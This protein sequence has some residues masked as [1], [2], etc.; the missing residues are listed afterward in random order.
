MGQVKHVD[1]LSVSNIKT[2]AEGEDEETH[3]LVL[4]W[5]VERSEEMKAQV[6]SS[7]AGKRG[8]VDNVKSW[9]RIESGMRAWSPAPSRVVIRTDLPLPRPVPR[10]PYISMLATAVKAYLHP[11]LS[12]EDSQTQDNYQI[13]ARIALNRTS[14][15]L[16]AVAEG[17]ETVLPNIRL[18]S[19][20]KYVLPI[21]RKESTSS[22]VVKMLTKGRLPPRCSIK[23]NRVVIFHKHI[24]KYSLNNWE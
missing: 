14:R 8:E 9:R 12:A 1:I 17:S 2:K 5:E 19:P 18:T 7:E 16:D 3:D 10:H 22:R 4:D 20:R 21:I 15:S 13:V 24:Y 6:K 11:H 23:G